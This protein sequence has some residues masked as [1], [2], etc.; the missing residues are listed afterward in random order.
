MIDILAALGFFFL[1][2]AGLYFLDA[3]LTFLRDVWRE[4]HGR[5]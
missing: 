1:V 5:A 3:A 4:F 2:A